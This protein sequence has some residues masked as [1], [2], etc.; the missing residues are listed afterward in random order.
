MPARKKTED[1]PDLFGSEAKSDSKSE[2]KKTSK[3]AAEKASN[4]ASQASPKKSSSA[5]PKTHS[6][7]SGQYSAADI[8]VLEGLEPVR[9]QIGRAHV[10][11]PV[12][13]GSR[14]PSSA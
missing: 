10:R 13:R 14:M 4:S 12:T 7:K 11:T 2:A 6:K 9:R 5:K 8:E 1:T 3:S